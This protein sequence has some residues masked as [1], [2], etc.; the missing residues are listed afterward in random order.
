[1]NLLVL[2]VHSI[3]SDIKRFRVKPGM[4][5]LFYPKLLVQFQLLVVNLVA[6]LLNPLQLF[7]VL[8]ELLFFFAEYPLLI[9]DEKGVIIVKNVFHDAQLALAQIGNEPGLI[10]CAHVFIC[11]VQGLGIVTAVLNQAVGAE[12][13]FLKAGLA[14]AEVADFSLD[15]LV[16]FLFKPAQCGLSLAV[17]VVELVFG[18]FAQNA[19]AGVARIKAAGIKPL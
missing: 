13:K 5:S 3:I 10:K 6:V 14:A 16:V 2:N 18:F 4:T 19:Q 17:N 1:M 15:F 12:D 9:V 8:V 7:L 11:A